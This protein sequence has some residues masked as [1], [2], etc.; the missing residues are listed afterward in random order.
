MWC[1]ERDLYGGRTSWPFQPVNTWSS[2]FYVGVGFL[3]V[4]YTLQPQLLAKV[5]RFKSAP[6]IMHTDSNR[7]NSFSSR[8]MVA[9]TVICATLLGIGSVIAHGR[10]PD[11]LL[12]PPQPEL[13][14]DPRQENRIWTHYLESL[15]DNMIDTFT[16]P[17]SWDR[18]GMY[19]VFVML[20]WMP[21]WRM[22]AVSTGKW[23]QLFARSE[24][25]QACICVVLFICSASPVFLLNWTLPKNE[26]NYAI[27]L[28]LCVVGIGFEFYLIA[29]IGHHKMGALLLKRTSTLKQCE[30]EKCARARAC[31]CAR[32]RQSSTS[33]TSTDVT[34]AVSLPTGVVDEDDDAKSSES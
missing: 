20:L 32:N 13:P 23:Q 31:A 24:I 34:I 2:L 14:W 9:Y 6:F 15:S 10:T 1:E 5:W 21:V 19:L 27:L 22:I 11:Y 29:L 26:W 17:S 25:L 12:A 3:I 28:L 4:L 18:F 8:V 33:S 16:D 30:C 7:L